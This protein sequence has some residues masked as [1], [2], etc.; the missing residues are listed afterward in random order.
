MVTYLEINVPSAADG[1]GLAL[2]TRRQEPSDLPSHH[3]VVKEVSGATHDHGMS[4]NPGTQDVQ[5]TS[6]LSP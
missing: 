3:G 4:L 1:S 2:T 6:P 5:N